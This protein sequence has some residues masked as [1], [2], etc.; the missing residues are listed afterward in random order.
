MRALRRLNLAENRI[1]TVPD[2][3]AALPELRMLDLAHNRIRELPEALGELSAL[4]D[5]LYLSDNL[6]ETIPESV[7]RGMSRLRYLGLTHNPLATLPDSLAISAV[8]KN[9]AST[10][11]DSPRFRTPSRG[12]ALCANYTCGTIACALCRMILAR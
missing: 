11:A 7:F 1:S 3:I 4:E 6:L 8:W 2:D 10:R 5:A 12:S 9:C